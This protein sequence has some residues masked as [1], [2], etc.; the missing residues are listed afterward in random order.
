M[1]GSANPAGALWCNTLRF[2]SPTAE[3]W[4]KEGP[5]EEGQV[6][7]T[8]PIPTLLILQLATLLS[9]PKDSAPHLTGGL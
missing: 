2:L 1:P 7:R 3:L 8:L 5:R 6:R 4:Q 9:C